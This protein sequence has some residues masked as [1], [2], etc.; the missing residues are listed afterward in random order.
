MSQLP[1]LFAVSLFLT[2]TSCISGTPENSASAD[3]DA[4]ECN[5]RGVELMYEGNRD[6]ALESFQDGLTDPHISKETKAKTYRNI[7]MAYISMEEEQDSAVHYLNLAL[8]LIPANSYEYL[9][10]SADLDLISGNVPEAEQKL[11]QAL[12]MNSEKI[13][14][15]DLLGQIYIGDYGREYRE[16]DKALEHNLKVWQY[17]KDSDSEFLLAKN[18]YL[19]DDLD[20]AYS[21]FDNLVIKDPEDTVSLLHKG[22]VLYRQGKKAEAEAIWKKVVQMDPGEKEYIRKFKEAV[23]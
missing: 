11:Q 21:H 17:R 12:A 10:N 23:G 7:A 20:N 13:M 22:M 15:H 6:E 14:A 18:Y 3:A 16:L 19:L 1:V 4:D 9:I 2:V 5:Q 8:K